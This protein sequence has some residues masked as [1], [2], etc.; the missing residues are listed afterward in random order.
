[1]ATLS[2]LDTTVFG[3]NVEYPPDSAFLCARFWDVLYLETDEIFAD[4]STCC[5]DERIVLEA[6]SIN[7]FEE[8]YKSGMSHLEQ[9]H[10]VV[11]VDSGPKSPCTPIEGTALHQHPQIVPIDTSRTC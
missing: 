10:E 1:M 2:R 8:T 4:I 11:G 6:R 7:A 5:D 3:Q 9:L